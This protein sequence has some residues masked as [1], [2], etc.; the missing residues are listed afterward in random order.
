[1]QQVRT[2]LF[3]NAERFQQRFKLLGEIHAGVMPRHPAKAPE[4]KAERGFTDINVLHE[5][6]YK[7]ANVA[8]LK[9]SNSNTKE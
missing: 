2:Y 1:M 7:A 6:K 5:I 3:L 9:I 8:F 4:S